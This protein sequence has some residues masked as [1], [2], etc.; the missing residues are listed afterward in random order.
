ML[1]WYK[2]KTEF[3]QLQE[4]DLNAVFL[5]LKKSYFWTLITWVCTFIDVIY[6]PC[7][8]S[9]IKCF[10]HCMAVF[11]GFVELQRYFCYITTD[12]YLSEKDHLNDTEH[13]KMSLLFKSKLGFFDHNH[14]I[15]LTF[16]S[17]SWFRPSNRD[18]FSIIFSSAE[19][20]AAFSF[21]VSFKFSVFKYHLLA[22]NKFFYIYNL[23]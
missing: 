10:C 6:K 17:S 8:C 14:T 7:K 4:S 20:S 18:I 22:W 15:R 21:S 11:F 16:L 9:G 2:H 1:N 3:I 19:V 23:N 5:Y 12:I 13:D